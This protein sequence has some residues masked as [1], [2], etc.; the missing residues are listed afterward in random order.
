M[1]YKERAYSLLKDWKKDD[2]LMGVGCLSEIGKRAVAFG[3]RALVIANMGHIGETVS[4]VIRSLE[5]SG[6]EVITGKAVKGHISVRGKYL[7][8]LKRKEKNFFRL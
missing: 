2:Y 4:A 3:H 7:K 8:A 5:L 6:I 1:N